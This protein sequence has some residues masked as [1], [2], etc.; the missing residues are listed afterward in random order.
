MEQSFT[1]TGMACDGC[2]ANVE[3][4]LG[5][6]D[7]VETVEADHERDTVEVSAADVSTSDLAAAIEDA[8]YEV[9]R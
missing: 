1:V 3:S 9:D 8:G 6:L 5:E 2:E 4:A 7:G